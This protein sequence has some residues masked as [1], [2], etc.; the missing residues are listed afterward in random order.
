M[1]IEHTNHLDSLGDLNDILIKYNAHIN[2]ISALHG[3]YSAI[4][5]SPIGIMPGAAHKIIWGGD[6]PVWSDMSEAMLFTET[7][8]A[9]MLH[10]A[11]TIDDVNEHYTP[12]VYREGDSEG[13][14][15]VDDWIMGFVEGISFTAESWKILLDDK[16]NKELLLPIIR[17]YNNL[18]PNAKWSLPKEDSKKNKPQTSLELIALLEKNVPLIYQF[19]TPH[20]KS[21]EGMMDT[22]VFITSPGIELDKPCPCG[23]GKKY[24]NCCSANPTHH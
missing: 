20:R 12:L 7:S 11:N 14:L 13:M 24:K 22:E 17:L 8:I 18:N 19:F 6:A 9:F 10:T 1:K 21:M 23:S 16:K 15:I 2:D 3:F 5:C 4:A